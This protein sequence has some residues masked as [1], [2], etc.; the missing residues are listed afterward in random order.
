MSELR[1]M[2][3]GLGQPYEYINSHPFTIFHRFVSSVN[4]SYIDCEYNK[5]Y[6]ELPKRNNSFYLMVYS[7]GVF[8][9]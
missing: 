2:V 5:T 3:L 7:D 6:E 8:I 4:M 9:I 1:P